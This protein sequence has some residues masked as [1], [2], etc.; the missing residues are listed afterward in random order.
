MSKTLEKSRVSYFYQIRVFKTPTKYS[1]VLW[2][3]RLAHIDKHKTDFESDERFNQYIKDIP[4]IIQNP[5]I[6]LVF[7]IMGLV[8]NI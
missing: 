1:Y 4:V 6:M 2:K 5:Q 8:L 3:A 7:T